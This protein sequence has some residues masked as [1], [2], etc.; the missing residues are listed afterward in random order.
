MEPTI[1]PDFIELTKKIY[2][3]GKHKTLFSLQTNGRL[4]HKFNPHSLADSGFNLI[5]V[6][7]DTFMPSVAY[8]Q[9]NGLRPGAVFRSLAKIIDSTNIRLRIV[10]VVTKKNIGHIVDFIGFCIEFGI[11]IFTLRQVVTRESKEFFIVDGV[12][13]KMSVLTIEEESFDELQK[14]VIKRFDSDAEFEFYNCSKIQGH[15][16]NTV[17]GKSW[18]ASKWDTYLRDAPESDSA[19]I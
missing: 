18:E 5:S 17:K 1:H 16:E 15:A 12:R 14:T 8:F 10:L 7:L 4:L 2:V 3:L 6:S 13:Y 19:K 11:K 9:R